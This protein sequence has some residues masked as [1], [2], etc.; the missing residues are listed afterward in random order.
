MQ[1][2][3]RAGHQLPSIPCQTHP[4]PDTIYLAYHARRSVPNTPCRPFLVGLTL[5][6]ILYRTPGGWQID[7]A[8]MPLI[9]PFS[10]DRERI[11]H[12]APA[13]CLVPGPASRPSRTKTARPCKGTRAGYAGMSVRAERLRSQ[14]RRTFQPGYRFRTVPPR[15]RHVAIGKRTAELAFAARYR[16]I[17]HVTPTRH[18][19][20]ISQ[21]MNDRTGFFFRCMMPINS[22]PTS[23]RNRVTKTT[24]TVTHWAA[25][26]SRMASRPNTRDRP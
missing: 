3:S 17:P 16:T 25:L 23:T 19:G 20:C 11:A 2:A 4:V 7:N 12:V 13:F 22:P 21:R 1:D 6:N 15:L 18:F 8:F 14:A 24:M 9:L 26:D 5:P 10:A